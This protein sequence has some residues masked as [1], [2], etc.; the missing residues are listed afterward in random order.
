MK[1]ISLNKNDIILEILYL[2]HEILLD[3]ILDWIN[4]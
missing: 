4:L 3:E 2:N 1:L